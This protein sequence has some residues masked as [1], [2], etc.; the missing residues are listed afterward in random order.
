VNVRFAGVALALVASFTLAACNDQ[1]E[2]DSPEG[3]QNPRQLEIELDLD[4]KT[5]TVTA[6]PLTTS[7][8]PHRA[9]ATTRKSVVTTTAKP[10]SK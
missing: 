4:A 9:P 5:K 1:S 2:S 3:G 8:P 10:R 6:P 7:Q